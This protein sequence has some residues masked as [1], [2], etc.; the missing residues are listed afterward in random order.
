MHFDATPCHSQC[1]LWMC[2][3]CMAMPVHNV[4]AS[5]R[6]QTRTIVYIITA[7]RYVVNKVWILHWWSDF[8]FLYLLKS[9]F[10]LYYTI[11]RYCKTCRRRFFFFFII[12][13][14]GIAGFIDSGMVVVLYMAETVEFS[15]RTHNSESFHYIY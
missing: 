13:L 10:S 6:Q 8:S 5:V 2:C 11:L 3:V 9:Y 14:W 15:S 1:L 12:Y 4:S 7:A